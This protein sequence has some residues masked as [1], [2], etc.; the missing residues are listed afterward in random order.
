MMK[1]VKNEIMSL[2]E[3]DF[4]SIFGK[5]NV[6]LKLDDGFTMRGK[7]EEIGWS[8]CL[9]YQPNGRLPAD[10]KINNRKIDIMKI[11]SIQLI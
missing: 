10:L 2:G 3:N 5:A 4:R 7:I 6:M 9:D 11:E 1:F 8:G